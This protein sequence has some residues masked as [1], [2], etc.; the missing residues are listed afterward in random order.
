MPLLLLFNPIG[1]IC[2]PNL[3]LSGGLDSSIALDPSNSSLLYYSSDDVQ[4]FSTQR[5]LSFSAWRL[6]HCPQFFLA[7]PGVGSAWCSPSPGQT[8]FQGRKSRVN[9]SFFLGFAVRRF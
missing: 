6:S 3:F 7:L 2:F 5:P 8:L 1:P 9:A 4:A